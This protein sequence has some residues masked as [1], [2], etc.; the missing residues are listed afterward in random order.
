MTVVAVAFEIGAIFWWI[1]IG[2]SRTIKLAKSPKSPKELTLEEQ[3]GF[4]SLFALSSFVA[5]VAGWVIFIEINTYFDFVVLVV[6][7]YSGVASA[8]FVVCFITARETHKRWTA[9]LLRSGR[10]ISRFP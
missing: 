6:L 9:E 5:A 8:V 3:V 4:D 2:R 10:P 7:C 1:L